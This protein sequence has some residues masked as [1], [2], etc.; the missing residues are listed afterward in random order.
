MHDATGGRAARR[1]MPLVLALVLTTIVVAAASAAAPSY[2]DWSSPVNLGSTVNATAADTNPALS[3]DGLS[4]Y[5]DSTRAGGA[6]GRDL[7]VS[8]RATPIAAWGPPV[9][10]GVVVNSA[11]D[12]SNAALSS[13]GHWL[14]FASTRPGG[15]GAADL[16]ESYRADISD[17]F[18]WQ[19]PNNLGPNINTAANENGTGGYFDN[20]GHPQLYFGSDRPGGLGAADIYRSDLQPD[21]TWG[22]ATL[23]TELSTSAQDNRPN[24][25][26]DGLEIFFYSNRPGGIGG[27]DLWTATRSSIDAA[28]STPVNLGPVVNT[29]ANDGHPYLSTDG[30]TLV[31]DSTRAGGFGADDLYVM[32]RA[33]KLTGTFGGG[34]RSATA[35]LRETGTRKPAPRTSPGRSFRSTRVSRRS[36]RLMPAQSRRTT[37]RDSA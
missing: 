32:T 13:D 7:W 23:V 9:D 20:G 27:N 2:T 26:P 34:S 5:F 29:S 16:Y 30:R 24:L 18:G 28:W 1:L 17:D 8:H 36:T 33:A 22:P 12:D 6:G 3:P 37:S 15:F 19:A 25:R 11:A 31:F 21:G 10:L 35:R 4:L 14:F